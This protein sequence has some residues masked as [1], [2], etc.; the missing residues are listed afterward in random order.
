[1][2][3]D[4]LVPFFFFLNLSK[5]TERFKKKKIKVI[6]IILYLRL[7]FTYK[8]QFK[9]FLG[10]YPFYFIHLIFKKSYLLQKINKKTYSKPHKGKLLY[11]RRNMD[12]FKNFKL[13]IDQFENW[14]KKSSK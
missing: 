11:E 9:T 10:L 1:M 3:Q 5:G 6:N 12:N 13:R 8:S 2:D 4:L 14:L 7:I